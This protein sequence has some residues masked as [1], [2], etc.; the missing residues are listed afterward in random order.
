MD[1]DVGHDRLTTRARI[2]QIV[3]CNEYR[4]PSYLAKISACVDVASKGRLNLGIGAGWFQ[5]EFQAFG[6]DYRTIG[7]R[8]A[9]LGESLEILKRLWTEETATFEGRHYRLVD[10]VCE[11]KR[12]KSRDLPSG[13]VAVARR[14]C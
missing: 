13:S 11:P 1:D 14:C 5:E 8:L 12:C 9:R 7:A 2:G 6:Y 3:T 4:S 10:A